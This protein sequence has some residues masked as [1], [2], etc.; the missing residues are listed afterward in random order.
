MNNVLSA[1]QGRVAGV[2]I[3]QNSGVAGAG[4]DIQI[5]GRNSLRSYNSGSSYEANVPLYIVDGVVLS[6]VM[7]SKQ[8]FPLVCWSIRRPIL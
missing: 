3:I 4:F 1:V 6:R 2:S 5:R 8:A 7:I